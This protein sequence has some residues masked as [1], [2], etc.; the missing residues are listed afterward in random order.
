MSGVEEGY[1]TMIIEMGILAPFLWILWT[2]ALL[3]YLWK[4]VRRLRET[5]LFPIGFAVLWYSFVLLYPLTFLGMTS[6]QN[7]VTNIY[8]WV[9]VG[10]VFRLPQ[11]LT[12]P[13]APSAMRS[14]E[15]VAG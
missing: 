14:P 11:L 12:A 5:R 9:L 10:V 3:Y 7:F 13:P 15:F 1:G 4:V 8:L 6:Y 2:A